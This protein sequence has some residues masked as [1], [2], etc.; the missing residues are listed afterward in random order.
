MSGL[1]IVIG[2][3]M[4]AALALMLPPLV[5]RRGPPASRGDYD[6]AVYM[7]QLGEVERDR[8]RGLLDTEQAAAAA[9]EIQRRML[10]AGADGAPAGVPSARTGALAAACV[11]VLVPAGAIGFYVTLG[12]P[13][14]P[15]HPFAER[16]VAEAEAGGADIERLV[17]R[18][19]ERLLRQPDDVD[20][21]VLLARTYVAMGRPDDAAGAYRRAH[22]VSGGEPG[23]AA[24]Y[25]EMLVTAAEGTVTPEAERLFR[26]SLEADPRAIKA[27]YYLGAAK[28]QA[29][30]LEGAL[31]AWVDLVALSPEGAP[32][33]EAV[34][35]Q[36]GRTADDLGVDA[37]TLRPKAEARLLAASAPGAPARPAPPPA[38]TRADMDAAAAMSA[39]ER[40]AMVRG[41]VERLAARLEL[42]PG[43]R[44]GWL[45]LGRSYEVL[46]ETEKA[47]RA[48]ARAAA[49]ARG[50]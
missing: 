2:L 39:E 38:P 41:M 14:A 37:A 23:V 47:R 49:L 36:I 48:F 28:A 15:D 1:A 10:A 44:Q 19:A 4:A 40:A 21:W 7:D 50:D 27:R 5:R 20:R 9:T 8:E 6:L 25:A 22:E 35:E 16:A 17:G 42:E 13:G 33:L 24:D 32:W 18:L 26:V 31:Q 46:G 30:D 12:Q 3:L 43:D 45:R 11:A 29:G 34:R